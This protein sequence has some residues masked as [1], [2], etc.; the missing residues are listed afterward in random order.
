MADFNFYNRMRTVTVKDAETF[1]TLLMSKMAALPV[2]AT[3]NSLEHFE[4]PMRTV[5]VIGW[6]W[7]SAS[8]MSLNGA[9]GTTILIANGEVDVRGTPNGYLSFAP[10]NGETFSTVRGVNITKAAA[11][12]TANGCPAGGQAKCAARLSETLVTE[13]M[14]DGSRVWKWPA[15]DPTSLS[16]SSEGRRRLQNFCYISDAY[17]QCKAK[18]DETY[19]ADFA[20]LCYNGCAN[21]C[22]AKP[23]TV[24]GDK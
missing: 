21:F 17:N 8:S 9:D 1:Q 19:N 22:D 14:C 23:Q 7:I 16:T 10:L 18:C 12:C 4:I 6:T 20:P 5:T 11:L 24:I 13:I 2:D 3:A 15:H